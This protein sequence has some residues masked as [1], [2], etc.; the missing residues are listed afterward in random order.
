MLSTYYVIV[1]MYRE[2]FNN[3]YFK[4][5]EYDN[6]SVLRIKQYTFQAYSPEIFQI[7][8]MPTT[9]RDFEIIAR[10]INGTSE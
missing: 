3:V 9:N 6:Y 1:I 5:T 10:N 8:V 7:Y 4:Y 2:C